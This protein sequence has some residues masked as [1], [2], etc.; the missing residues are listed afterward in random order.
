MQHS[1]LH[2]IGRPHYSLQTPCCKR[3][4]THPLRSLGHCPLHI[5][6]MQWTPPRTFHTPTPLIQMHPSHCRDHRA[7]VVPLYVCQIISFFWPST[8]VLNK[9]DSIFVQKADQI[10]HMFTKSL[11]K[12]QF[13]LILKVPFF[14]LFYCNAMH[15]NTRTVSILPSL[16]SPGASA[17]DGASR[18]VSTCGGG[19]RQVQRRRI[20]SYEFASQ[21]SFLESNRYTKITEAR[22]QKLRIFDRFGRSLLHVSCLSLNYCCISTSIVHNQETLYFSEVYSQSY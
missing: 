3:P 16:S 12:C 10:G 18:C 2:Q 8:V 1:Y 4:E 13:S 11:S 20:G 7:D 15:W 19:S 5:A 17:C 21:L 6:S 22:R 9:Q 14:F